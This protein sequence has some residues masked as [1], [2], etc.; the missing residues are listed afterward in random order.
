MDIKLPVD[1]QAEAV[2]LSR[3]MASV[4]VVN[5]VFDTLTDADFFLPEHQA[6]FKAMQILFK[7]D[8]EIEPEAVCRVIKQHFPDRVDDFL[9]YGLEVHRSHYTDDA[10]HYIENV[11]DY[12]IYRRLIHQAKE[13]LSIAASAKVPPSQMQSEITSNLDMIFNEKSENNLYHLGESYFSE[14]RESGKSY[15]Q[16]LE[17]KQEDFANGRYTLS[18]MPSGF[19]L[20]D[21]TIDGFNKGHFIIIGA[22]P[23]VG[24]TTFILN[25]IR[26]MSKKNLKIGFFSLEATLSEIAHSYACVCAGV[27]SGRAKK[28]RI[29]A[30]EYQRIVEVV[31]K[32][33]TSNIWID[34]RASLKINQVIART[35]RMIAHQN[36]DILF[37]DYLGEVKGDGKFTTKQEEMQV[38]SRGLRAIAKQMNIPVVCVAQLNRESEKG[39]RIPI[40]SDLRES[41]QIEADAH[42]IIMLHRP[43]MEDK[44]NFP[45]ILNAH[46]VKN[47]YGEEKKISFSFEKKT[48]VLTELPEFVNPRNLDE[49]PQKDPF[50]KYS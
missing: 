25:L 23:G 44:N 26:G 43:D 2:V 8:A 37:V 19:N 6:I 10:T 11:K 15:L 14:Y 30:E 36:I 31:N 4:N 46:I 32:M 22:R 38:V 39:N 27:E 49:P 47:R 42:A 5:D 24:K 29:D 45:G 50:G 41:G 34:E 12:S 35:K 40:K 3:M 13:I 9:V 21:E 33:K 48:G 18:G 7:S 17:K 20:L 16:Y 1:L 28:G